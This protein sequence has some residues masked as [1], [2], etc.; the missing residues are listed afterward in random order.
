MILLGQKRTLRGGDYVCD[1]FVT[2]NRIIK[3]ARMHFNLNSLTW[4][5]P[6]KFL[7]SR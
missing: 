7:Y 5:P 2:G 4:Y 1:R 3:S 6:V